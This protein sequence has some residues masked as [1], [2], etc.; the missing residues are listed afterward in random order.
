M[1][2]PVRHLESTCEAN[3]R[4]SSRHKLSSFLCAY[5]ISIVFSVPLFAVTRKVIVD[6][7]KV[8]VIHV[9]IAPGETAEL[10]NR[11]LDRVIVWL[12]G[13]SAETILPGGKSENI[14]W[15]QN[16]AQW[17]PAVPSHQMRLKGKNPVAA[18][19]VELKSKGD[20]RNTATSPQNP[21]IIDPKHYKLEFE[22]GVVRVTR[23]NIGPKESTP[24][25]EH[26]LDRV[27]VYLTALDFRIDPEG[28]QPEHSVFPA[29]AVAWGVPVRHTEHNL[30]D[31]RFEAIVIEPKY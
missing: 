16:D 25:H 4:L 5:A 8:R 17:E 21:W 22:N 13:G 11:K 9:L 20:P 15:K 26:S 14:S 10:D 31:Q 30:S 28:K 19:V 12:Q 18:I 23:V 29:G 3:M 1:P 24:L 6:N 27:V 7:P 2:Q